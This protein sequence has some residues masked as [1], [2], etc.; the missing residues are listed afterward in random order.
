MTNFPPISIE[1]G[2]PDDF[3]PEGFVRPSFLSLANFGDLY[4]SQIRV[5][6]G[7]VKAVERRVAVDLLRIFLAC[8]VPITLW[9]PVGARKT[10]TIEALSRLTDENGTPYQVITMQ[11]STQDSSIISGI[12]YTA[13][14]PK[15]NEVVMKRSIPD[16]AK[17]VVE[18]WRKHR[19]LTI[20]FADEMTTCMVSQ[21]NAML[22][23]LTHG[24]F[25]SHD[26]NPYTSFCMAANPQ[27][28][29]ST[30]NPLGEA[31]MNR[32]GH[33]AWYGDVDLF[34]SD[35]KSGWNGATTP[36]PD[37]TQWYIDQIIK[38]DKAGAFRNP[39]KWDTDEL[40]PWDMMEHSERSTTN[41][42]DI[43]TFIDDV[44][45]SDTTD[46]DKVRQHYIIEATQAL[47]GKAWA[48]KM[49]RVIAIENASLSPASIIEKV[50]S[51]GITHQSDIEDVRSLTDVLHVKD[52]VPINQ[53]QYADAASKLSKA[54]TQN[55]E[56]STENYI[57]FWAFVISSLNQAMMMSARDA[58]KSAAKQAVS[59]VK[60]G[61]IT[62]A[63]M[64]PSFLQDELLAT[65]MK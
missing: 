33:I 58:M 26:I 42:A 55:G 28:T 5:V 7:E 61:N 31:V 17:Q 21:Q 11:P 4:A 15:D 16:V 41:L 29:V 57:S 30:V 52:G 2:V 13:I 60:S 9:G 34:L 20:I 27:G 14:D 65:L 38:Q 53:A 62:Q 12:F 6:D 36:P 3:I 43:V 23:V 56:F 35:W 18:Y 59:A 45:P 19:G 64:K 48:N 50:R 39:E 32:G 63:V 25:D 10:R 37:K 47:Q 24:K 51:A 54:I 40:I 46:Q 49:R 8:K 1:D 22:G 44:F